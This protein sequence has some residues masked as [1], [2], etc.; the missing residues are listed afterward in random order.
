MKFGRTTKDFLKW[1]KMPVP[2]KKLNS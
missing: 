1:N 2:L